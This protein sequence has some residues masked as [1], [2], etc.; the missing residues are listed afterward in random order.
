MASDSE[1]HDKETKAGLRR[2]MKQ[3]TNTPKK[4]P[5]KK[6]DPKKN[7]RGQ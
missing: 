3:I 5:K 1:K 2:L 6:P 4:D 7:K